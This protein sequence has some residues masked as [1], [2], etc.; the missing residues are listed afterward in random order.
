MVQLRFKIRMQKQMAMVHGI[1]K[2]IKSLNHIRILWDAILIQML[3]QRIMQGKNATFI[4]Q[5]HNK[6]Q[7]LAF[8]QLIQDTSSPTRD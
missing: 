6:L 5:A 2:T 8:M 7:I 4:L 3:K 1:S